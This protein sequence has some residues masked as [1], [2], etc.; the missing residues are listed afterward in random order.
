MNK[1]NSKNE[2]KMQGMCDEGVFAYVCVLWLVDKNMMSI[3]K[4]KIDYTEE[5]MV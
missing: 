2:E 5:R 3:C 4:Q 1:Y